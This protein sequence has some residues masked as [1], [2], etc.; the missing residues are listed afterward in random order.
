MMQ[1][2]LQQ[3]TT[4]PIF[5]LTLRNRFCMSTQQACDGLPYGLPVG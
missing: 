2:A 1:Q 5:L 3:Q 4:H